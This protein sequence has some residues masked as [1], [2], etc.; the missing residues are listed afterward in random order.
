MSSEESGIEDNLDGSQRHILYV[1]DL[2][3]RADVTSFL[4]LDEKGAK[5]KSKK[6]EM[7]TRPRI[8]KG[9]SDRAKPQ[10][11]P[12]NHWAFRGE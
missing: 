7:Q 11:F 9:L 3:W 8:S 5:K 4:R 12:E 10:M 1:S 6:S 2:C